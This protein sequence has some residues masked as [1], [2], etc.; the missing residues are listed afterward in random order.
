MPDLRV[1]YKKIGFSTEECKLSRTR[2]AEIKSINKE[3]V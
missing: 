2:K 1:S 3:N